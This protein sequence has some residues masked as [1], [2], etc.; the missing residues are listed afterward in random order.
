M[1]GGGRRRNYE[2]YYKQWLFGRRTLSEIAEKLGISLPTLRQKFDALPPVPNIK[3]P[4]NNPV[5]L[6]ID[7]TFFGREYGYLCFHDGNRIIHFQEISAESLAELDAGLDALIAVGYRFKSFTLDGKR[8]FIRRLKAR[9]PRA[10]VQMCHFHQKAIIR[11]YITNNPQ[12]PCGMALK[13]LMTRF[14]EQE[15]Q[16]W[17]DALFALQEEYKA[18]LA[19]K[20]EN[21]K[22]VHRRIRSAF[23]SLRTNLPYLFVYAEVPSAQIPQTTNRLEGLFSHLKEKIRLHRGLSENRK[24]KAIQ[25]SL[26]WS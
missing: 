20:N 9:F 3:L 26:Y 17:I 2:V 18:F 19:E 16:E 24:K 6:L 1:S 22:Y 5:N 23:R 15:P 10:P 25:Y 11:R 12:T 4:H 14:G 21:G 8:G 7:A 13:E